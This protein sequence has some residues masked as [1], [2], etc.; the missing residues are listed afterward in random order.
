[1]ADDDYLDTD[2]PH[3]AARAL[4]LVTIALAVLALAAAVLVHV[5]ETVTGRFTLVPVN[6][7]DPV[8]MIRDG[9]VTSV[10]ASD[11][12]SVTRGTPL[13]VIRSSAL[14]DRSADRLSFESQRR[15][16]EARLAILDG[17]YRIQRRADSAEERRLLTRV[18]YLERQ[19][20]SRSRRL[21][22][23]REIADSSAAGASRGSIGRFEASRLEFD[24]RSLAE[25]LEGAELELAEVRADVVRLDSDR[26]QRDLDHQEARRALEE[27]IE[28]A[29]IR[30]GSL[31]SDLANITD[32][33]VVL[34]AP[35]TGTVLR[36]RVKAPGAVVAEG[37]ILGEVACLGELLQG[38]LEVP[39][40]G[41]P[42]I[43]AGQD[44]KLRF[45]AFPYQ[46]YG[47]RF[48]TVRWLG[49]SGI[50]V[51][52]D[53]SAFRAL[54]ALRD[55]AIRVRGRLRPLLAGMSGEADIVV[56]RRSLVSYAFEPIRALKES[57]AEAP[58]P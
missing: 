51:G 53:T 41:L 54:V 38:E 11:G 23:L 20:T 39:E 14:A 47:V 13:F 28:T 50:Q 58:A 45:D 40:S 2:P 35:C 46:R 15:G 33:G 19:I 25:E 18:A 56:G 27:T 30:A 4:A 8:R 36:L 31:R 52:N 44:V 26:R 12:D 24:A 49:P 1:M 16:S 34:N 6:G 9:V 21:G 42:F 57:F 43:Q 29:A 37:A 32:S 5:P 10:R 55:S 17:Q 3:W 7:T 22:L 48:G